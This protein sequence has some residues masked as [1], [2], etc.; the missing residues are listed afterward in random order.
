MNIDNNVNV[1]IGLIK[2]VEY[3]FNHDGNI[4]K[5]CGDLT[6]KDWVIVNGHKLLEK[7]SFKIHEC[8]P[9]DIESEKYE[10]VLDAKFGKEFKCSLIK[11]GNLIKRLVIKGKK[12]HYS[13][14]TYLI[15]FGSCLL[16]GILPSTVLP[17]WFLSW[18]QILFVFLA[19]F[20]IVIL[21]FYITLVSTGDGFVVEEIE[22]E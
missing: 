15:V 4:I 9:F 2:G 10:I 6:G 20:I 8:Y 11:N 19:V 18:P 7:R 12:G 17:S 5:L 1:S 22:S 21:I 3:T 14:K 13:L 16:I